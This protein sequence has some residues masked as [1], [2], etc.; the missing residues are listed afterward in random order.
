MNMA[1]IPICT[2]N[3]VFALKHKDDNSNGN[4]ILFILFDRNDGDKYSLPEDIFFIFL[5]LKNNVP[6]KFLLVVIGTNTNIV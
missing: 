6:N 5:Y 4:I 3:D 1:T 2:G